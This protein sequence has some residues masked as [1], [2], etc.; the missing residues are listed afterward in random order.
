MR[1]DDTPDNGDS[2]TPAEETHADTNTNKPKGKWTK[3]MESP[4]KKGRP[5][6]PRNIAELREL[7]REK[8]GAAVECLERTMLNPKVNM[9]VRLGAAQELLNRGWGRTPQS[10]D[11]NH[12]TQDSL[13]QLLEQISGRYPIKTIE[14]AAI[15]SPLAIEQP[16]HDLGEGR[17][18][19]SVPPE[20]GPTKTSG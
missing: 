1:H 13:A 5:R 6:C 10:L 9:N 12:G 11:V 2:P 3:G 19:D 4:N 8:T 14:G 15:R 17:S 7:C 20:L 18:E 16:L